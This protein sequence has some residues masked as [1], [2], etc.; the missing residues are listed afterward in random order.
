MSAVEIRRELCTVYGQHLT[1]EGTVR[2]RCK[3]LEDWRTNAHEVVGWPS[4]VSDDLVQSV[5]QKCCE[6]GASQFQNFC[7]NF[8]KF[9][10]N[11]FTRLLQLG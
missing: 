4:V 3:I 6:K 9:Y 11:F 2:Q 1:I 10:A 8:H 5:D 7:V